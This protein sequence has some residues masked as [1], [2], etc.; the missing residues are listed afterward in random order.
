[1]VSR[2]CAGG[3]DSPVLSTASRGD[4]STLD[5]SIAGARA[6]LSPVVTDGM[7]QY[8]MPMPDAYHSANSMHR[9]TP[10]HR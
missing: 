7:P 4:N 6:S 5:G 3:R 2:T 1:V 10:I 8:I 9:I